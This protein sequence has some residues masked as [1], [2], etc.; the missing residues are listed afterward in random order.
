LFSI[1]R[2]IIH[3]NADKVKPRKGLLVKLLAY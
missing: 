1:H 3:E 2:L